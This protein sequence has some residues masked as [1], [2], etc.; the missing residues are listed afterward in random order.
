MQGA[1]Y[2][3]GGCGATPLLLGS[4]PRWASA[5]NPP[6][7]RYAL[8]KGERVAGFLFG[9]PLTAG[10]PEPPSPDKILWAAAS[11][12]DGMPLRLTGHPLGT[13]KPAGMIDLAS[14]FDAG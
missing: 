11:L 9:Y 2:T 5:A 7:I 3:S 12:P 4:A 6:H 1:A 10:D 14:R 13:V 8:A